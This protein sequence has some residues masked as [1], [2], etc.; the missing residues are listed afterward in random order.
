MHHQTPSDDHLEKALLRET[1]L[2][3]GLKNQNIVSLITVNEILNTIYL[4]MDY[5]SNGKL[6]DYLLLVSQNA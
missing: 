6:F 3:I 5:C 1:E 2:L 4:I